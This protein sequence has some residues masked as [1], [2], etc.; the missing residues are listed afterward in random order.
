MLNEAPLQVGF[1]HRVRFG[2][3][4]GAFVS[5]PGPLPS[6]GYRYP[7]DCPSFE[8]QAED[9]ERRAAAPFLW[10]EPLFMSFTPEIPGPEVLARDRSD[11][12]RFLETRDPHDPAS[13]QRDA[14]G[15]GPSNRFFVCSQCAARFREE[16]AMWQHFD[17][18]SARLR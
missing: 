11:D 9:A 8:L 13:A 7:D 5:L 6:L 17:T 1:F 15:T 4:W 16:E 14:G 3:H 10:D 12:D 2:G 18:H